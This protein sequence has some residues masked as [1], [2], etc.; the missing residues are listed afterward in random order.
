[1]TCKNC[2][3]A[4]WELTTA[5]RISSKHCGECRMPWSV[6]TDGPAC[7]KVTV[8]KNG[9]WPDTHDD[10]RRFRPKPKDEPY[11]ALRSKT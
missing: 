10:C 1:M 11:W 2:T 9:I 4:A 8:Q 3:F 7:I 6:P 5:G